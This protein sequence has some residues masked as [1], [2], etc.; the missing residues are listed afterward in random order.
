MKAYRTHNGEDKPVGDWIREA[1]KQPVLQ[2]QELTITLAASTAVQSFSHSLGR[3]YRGVTVWGQDD[4][5][6]LITAVR[7]EK[8]ADAKARFDL[9][10]TVAVA[11][12]IKVWV[13]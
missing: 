3:F 1:E 12:T 9:R 8:A 7:P 2:G 11:Q 4:G 13:C 5:S 10:Q 6:S